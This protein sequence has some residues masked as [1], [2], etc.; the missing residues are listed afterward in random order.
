MCS[1]IENAL[2][3]LLN[4]PFNHLSKHSLPNYLYVYIDVG[5]VRSSFYTLNAVCG[6]WLAQISRTWGVKMCSL[7]NPW[8]KTLL[9]YAKC[10]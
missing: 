1:L 2:L 5:S 9:I 10:Q 8:Q 4:V 6:M 3:Y 7:K